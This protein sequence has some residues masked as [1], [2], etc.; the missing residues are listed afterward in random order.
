M[1]WGCDKIQTAQKT[2]KGNI[3][4]ELKLSDDAGELG[5]MCCERP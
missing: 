5:E 2:V 1:S 4:K 3:K